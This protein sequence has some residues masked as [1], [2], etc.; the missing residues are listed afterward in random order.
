MSCRR[1]GR[2][3]DIEKHHIIQRVDGGTDE[4]ENLEDLCSACHDYEHAKREII[5]KIGHTQEKLNK[6]YKISRKNA[7][8]EYL[9]MLN[10]RLEVLKSLNAP[11]QIR[12]TGKYTTYWVV[13]TTHD[14][15]P[16]PPENKYYKPPMEQPK[17]L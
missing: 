1:C 6:A 16:I 14:I 4:P 7:L 13:E 15:I 5:N 11:E 9:D 12:L 2:N 17:L 8:K 10:H 3:D